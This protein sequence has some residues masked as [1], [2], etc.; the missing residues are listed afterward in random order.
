MHIGTVV[1][2]CFSVISMKVGLSDCPHEN[3]C[4]ITGIDVTQ[5]GREETDPTPVPETHSV[6]DVG[7]P[8][9]YLLSGELVFLLLS[10]FIL[11]NAEKEGT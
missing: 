5:T 11:F 8:P 9:Y 4:S 10:H 2:F 7:F 6:R 3:T 1:Y